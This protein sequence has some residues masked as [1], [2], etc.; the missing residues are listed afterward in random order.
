M[1]PLP[2]NTLLS[3]VR[4]EAIG[5][6]GR[7]TIERITTDSRQ[8][9]PGDLFWA[10]RGERADGHD[11]IDEALRRGA[12]GAVVN[13]T[14]REQ[15]RRSARQCLVV[16]DTWQA[17]WDLAA[18]HRARSD[19]L[20][21]GVTGSVG[22]S[23]TRHLLH[24]ARY[25]GIQS[26]HN[27]HNHL[28][29]PL[30]LLE[31]TPQHE[32]AVLEAGASGGSEIARLCTLMQPEVGLLTAI[33]PAHLEG[34]GSLEAICRAKGELLE[35]LPPSGFAVLNGDDPLVRRLARR[36]N[37]RVLFV[38]ES[39]HN[40]VVATR[41]RV[42][43]RRLRFRVDDVEFQLPA[44]GRHHLTSAL[45]TVATAR[46]LDVGDTE[47]AA[48]LREFQPL[49]GRCRKLSIGPWTIIDDTYNANPASVL[50]ACQTL[51]DWEEAGQR[52]LV[53]GDMLELGPQAPAF[54]E[55]IGAAAAQ[56]GFDRV[57]AVGA[58]A[59]AVA[60]SARRHGLDVGCLGACS[61]LETALV[62]LDLW[63]EPNGVVLVKGSRGMRMERVVAHLQSRAE[64]EA[65]P[66]SGRDR[67]AA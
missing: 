22:K 1:H 41:V 54:H 13:R 19:A 63:L 66:T 61:D 8:V 38:G 65:L 44:I 3:A 27:F 60:G 28:G 31:L 56:C 11:F 62:L 7:V 17:L 48:A 10:L 12:I 40:D 49:P 18:W 42:N 53:L 39:I 16:P 37:C 14:W 29:V 52:V 2:L 55:H 15:Q 64:A 59:A 5:F 23:T 30:S 25:S 33:A 46:E 57:I 47:I 34:F 58:H 67:R 36:A 24:G 50:A 6:D 21:I 43:D 51:R 20:V 32:F 26:P 45:L 35:A 9:A 4:G